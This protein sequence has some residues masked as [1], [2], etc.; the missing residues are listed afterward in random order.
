ML[1]LSSNVNFD[2]VLPLV[3]S[4]K[5]V[6]VTCRPLTIDERCTVRDMLTYN[7]DNTI[8]LNNAKKRLFIF[9]KCVMGW[10]N[11]VDENDNRV[12][13]KRGI[14]GLDEDLI[15]MFPLEIIEHVA[16]EI[17]NH[18]NITESEEKN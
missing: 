18:S 14:G 15:N 7:P 10:V 5:E 3:D 2:V 1:K 6:I 16:D 11:I 9:R 8:N 17:D 4:E 12:E 13:C